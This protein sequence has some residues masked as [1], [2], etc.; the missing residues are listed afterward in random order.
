MTKEYCQKKYDENDMERVMG[1]I[2][3]S[4]DLTYIAVASRKMSNGKFISVVIVY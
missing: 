4:S 1:R 3:R 2:M